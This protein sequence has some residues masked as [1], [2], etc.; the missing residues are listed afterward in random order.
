[1]AALEAA[2]KFGIPFGGW[3]PTGSVNE[4]GPIADEYRPYMKETPTDDVR[5]RTKRNVSDSDATLVLV[6]K[7]L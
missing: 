6:S 3:V 1:M 2:H 7:I 5:E 4:L